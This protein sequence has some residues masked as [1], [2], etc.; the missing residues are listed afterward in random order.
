MTWQMN[1][2]HV[3]FTDVTD[4]CAVELAEGGECAMAELVIMPSDMRQFGKDNAIFAA[5]VL[6]NFSDVDRTPRTTAGVQ[7]NHGFGLKSSKMYISTSSCWYLDA[8]FC[9]MFNRMREGFA[10][11]L[12]LLLIR[13]GSFGLVT[14]GGCLLLVGVTRVVMAALGLESFMTKND[15][16][17]K[18]V[19]KMGETPSLPKRALVSAGAK[20]GEFNTLQVL[21]TVFTLTFGPVFYFQFFGPCWDCFDFEATVAHEVGH[22]LGFGHPDADPKLNVAVQINVT[23]G[24]VACGMPLDYVQLEEPIEANKAR[25][26]SVMFSFTK[27]RDRTCLLGDDLDGL[28]FLYPSCTGFRT[29][30]LCLKQLQLL[31]YIRLAVAAAVPFVCSTAFLMILLAFARWERRR[32]MR[33]IRKARRK[34]QMRNKWMRASLRAT[35][36]ARRSSADMIGLP[37]AHSSGFNATGP[38]NILDVLKQRRRKISEQSRAKSKTNRTCRGGDLR[39]SSGGPSYKPRA[40]HAHSEIGAAHKVCAQIQDTG[41]SIT[42]TE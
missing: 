27:H 3:S 1:S 9:Y 25:D 38:R 41:H 26:T 37:G 19:S 33:I 21:I 11:N 7:L 14:F 36:Q 31:G 42:S 8:T 20:L 13:I 29:D 10:D 4:E 24:K 22:V 35:L 23:M 32:E 2:Q 5:M 17:R 40:Q 15:R 16:R 18:D 34:S 6:N 39:C 28:N 30:P 12:V